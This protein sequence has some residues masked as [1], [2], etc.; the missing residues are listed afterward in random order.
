M[1][2]ELQGLDRKTLKERLEAPQGVRKPMLSE[3]KESAVPSYCRT[4]AV[5]S[6]L[7]TGIHQICNPC[8]TAPESVGVRVVC[9]SSMSLT[10]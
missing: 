2:C 5:V 9:V 6:V 1:L 4:P 3:V 10:N 7:E 8:S